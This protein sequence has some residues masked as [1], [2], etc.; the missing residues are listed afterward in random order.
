MTLFARAQAGRATES[1]RR[2][3]APW[4][5]T[6]LARPESA[7]RQFRYLPE[8]R[9]GERAGSI[10]CGLRKSGVGLE[11][12]SGRFFYSIETIS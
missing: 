5:Q 1:G 4:P 9:L 7:G 11:R 10:F 3:A 8:N 12:V 6:D 2:L